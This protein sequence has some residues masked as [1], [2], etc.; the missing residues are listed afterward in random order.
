VLRQ[1]AAADGICSRRPGLDAGQIESSVYKIYTMRDASAPA[2]PLV[3]G[4]R[5][6]VTNYAVAEG[7]I[8]S[9]T[10]MAATQ[11]GGSAW[12]GRG[13]YRPGGDE[14]Y[15]DLLGGPPRSPTSSRRS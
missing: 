9:A 2:P 3:N 7:D 1:A 8:S 5:I 4:R 12:A 11:A 13:Q 10:A 14:T 15:E 6:L